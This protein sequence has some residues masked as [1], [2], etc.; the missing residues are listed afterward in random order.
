MDYKKTLNLPA[1]DF[2]MKASLARREPELLKKWQDADIYGQIQ[3]RTQDRPPWVLHDGPPYANGHIHMGTALN[4]ILKDIIIKSKVMSGYSSPY[5]PGWDCH[6]LPIEHQVDQSLGSKKYSLSRS[7]IRNLCRRHAEKFVDIQSKQFQRLGVFGNWAQPYL[8]M[9]YDYEAVIARELGRTA[10]DGRLHHSLK[11]VLWCGQCRTALAEAEVEYQDVSSDSVFVAFPLVSDPSQLNPQLTGKKVSAV[12]WT[13]TP[14]T[15]PANMAVAYNP[16]V[17]YAAYDAGDRVLIVAKSLAE[18]LWTKFKL[19]PPKEPIALETASLKGL[20]TRH[21]LYERDSVLLPALYVTLEQGTGLV[22]T[23]PGHGREDYET[24]LANNLPIFSPLDEEARFTGEVPELSGQ[25]VPAANPK[26]IEM[27]REKGALIAAETVSHSYPHCWRCR[28]P[29]VFRATLQW[30]IS[31]EEKNL[32]QESLK[33]INRVTWIPK[34]GRER[35]YGMIEN[36]PDWCVSRQRSWGVPITIFFCQKCGKWHYSQAISDHLYGLF[37]AQGADAWY[38]LE[39]GQLLP[40]GEKCQACGHDEFTKESDILDVWFDSGSSFAAVLEPNPQLPD[41]ADMYLEGSDQHRGWFHSSLLI[42][43]AN[44]HTA[45]YKEV[46]THGYVVDG[47]GRKMSKSLG[48]TIDPESVINKFGADIIRLW[49]AAENYQDDIR[50]SAQILDMLAKAYFNFRNTIRFAIGNLYDFTAADALPYSRLDAL[51]RFVLHLLSVLIEKAKNA[52]ESYAFHDVYQLVNKF[53]G[54]ISSFYF[55]VV[56]DRLYTLGPRDPRRRGTQTVMS[57][58]LPALTKLMAPIIS[59]T[60]EEIWSYIDKSPDASVFLTDF[61][62]ARAEYFQ[63]QLAQDME[64]II[65]VR[66]KV[67][68]ALEEARRAKLIGSG[69]EAELTLAAPAAEYALLKKY[70]DL[71]LEIFIISRLEL[72]ETDSEISATVAVSQD[73]KC[74]R[75]WMRHPAV[76]SD[77]S[78]VCPKCQKALAERE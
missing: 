41:Q 46:L 14:W 40:A 56:K 37:L 1:T 72:I 33:A 54:L 55:D 78:G 48:N 24:G 10:L 9:S 28:K 16:A 76:P 11:P 19:Q 57:L 66:D 22:H 4:K 59:F 50:I 45:P 69:L 44:R 73:P 35:I 3:A 75:C 21:P 15:I 58:L 65:S 49:V 18:G 12:I 34:W 52:Y 13:T 42:S 53:V 8:T 60:A 64:D 31:M 32:R 43:I 74:P 29:V 77:Q 26:V 36:R 51:D 67:N 5:I 70:E 2:P 27:L 68:K 63:P 23:A 39:A 47:S 38:N 7:E 71:L 30:F 61:P 20:I 62:Q 25:K 17:E 6:G